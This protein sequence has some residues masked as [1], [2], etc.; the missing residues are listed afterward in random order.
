MPESGAVSR[1][2]LRLPVRTLRRRPSP[3]WLGALLAM[4]LLAAGCSSDTEASQGGYVGVRPSVTLVSPAERQPA[5]EVVGGR[6][7]GSGTISTGQYAGKVVV[8][9]V[10]GSWCGPCRLEAPDLAEASRETA[11]RAQFLGLNTKDPS[12]AAAEAFV[13][14]FEIGYPSIYDP[15]GKVLLSFAGDLPPSGIP[16]TLILDR[17]G[18][19]AARVIG[20]I[21]KITLVNLIDDVAAGR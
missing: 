16:S 14:A 17:E 18:R 15:Q 11:S 8:L 9:N 1:Q 21:S 4:L 3:G 13:R 7:G 5:P 20:P 19:I 6:L 12:P 10:W 2:S